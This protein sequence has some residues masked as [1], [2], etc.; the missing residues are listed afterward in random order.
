M[1]YII[2]Y[3]AETDYIKVYTEGE[4]EAMVK[5]L[6]REGYGANEITIYE[7]EALDFTVTHTDVSISTH[8]ED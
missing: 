5:D 6:V 1:V 4:A 8:K 2:E 7:A 3:N